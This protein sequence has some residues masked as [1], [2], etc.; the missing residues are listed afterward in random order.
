MLRCSK[1]ELERKNTLTVYMQIRKFD[2]FR[3]LGTDEVIP[4]GK[5]L[6]TLFAFFF[7]FFLSFSCQ[8]CC[9]FIQPTLHSLSSSTLSEISIFRPF[10]RKTLSHKPAD[11]FA[12]PDSPINALFVFSSSLGWNFNLAWHGRKKKT[13]SISFEKVE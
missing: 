5:F 10:I 13:L 12:S 8:T 4:F 1:S 6:A 7:F 11:S 2:P 3:F 9:S